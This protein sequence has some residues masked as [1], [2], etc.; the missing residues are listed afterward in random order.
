MASAYFSLAG[1]VF[2]GIEAA[3]ENVAEA[4]AA[5]SIAAEGQ[6]TLD[7]LST[8]AIYQYFAGN[9]KA[10]DEAARKAEGMASKSEAKEVKKKMAEYRAQGKSFEQQKKESPNRKRKKAKNPCKTPSAAWAAAAPSA[11]SRTSFFMGRLGLEPRTL[12]LR[13]SCSNQLS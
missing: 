1:I 10:G 8:L 9:F 4:A 2:G 5:Q 12:S 11:G 3:E 7:S 6:P 13:G